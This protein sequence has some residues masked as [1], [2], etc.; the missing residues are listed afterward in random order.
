MPAE[1]RPDHSGPG[2]GETQGGPESGPS[3]E[4]GVLIR[5]LRVVVGAVTLICAIVPPSLIFDWSIGPVAQV[6][7]AIAAGGLLGFHLVNIFRTRVDLGHWELDDIWSLLRSEILAGCVSPIVIIVL[8]LTLPPTWWMLLLLGSS[9]GFSQLI[10]EPV[11]REIRLKVA[12]AHKKHGTEHFRAR[13]FLEDFGVKKSLDEM[14]E[15]EQGPGIW[16]YLIALGEDP[17]QEGM[18]RT[19]SL[20]VYV[21]I[22][23][24]GF[25]GAASADVYVH[26]AVHGKGNQPGHSKTDEKEA[27]GGS[28]DDAGSDSSDSSDSGDSG[29]GQDGSGGEGSSSGETVPTAGRCQFN[30]GIG[31]PG[32]AKRDLYALYYGGEGLDATAPPGT[33]I[34]GCPSEV[35][36]LPTPE[37]PFV[38][39]VGRGED[40]EIITAAVTSR[41]GRP[42]IFLAPAAQRVIE[43][44]GEGVVPLGGY[45]RVDVMGDG[46]EGDMVPITTPEGTIVLVRSRKVLMDMPEYASPYLELPVAVAAAWTAAMCG[47]GEWLWP[48]EP[49]QSEGV[50]VYRFSRNAN[51]QGP[52]VSIVYDPEEAMATVGDL[53]YRSPQ[54]QLNQLELEDFAASAGE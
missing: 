1:E 10:Y 38:Y 9:F 53:E 54:A 6:V 18:S 2:E 23:C 37:G 20:I 19:R 32:W 29:D 11:Q 50:T 47:E 45:P 40:G 8:V 13:K 15:D 27:T 26:E 39:A 33:D 35:F 42:A 16:K 25:A 3:R 22:A 36:V 31:V 49:R 34:G 7:L 24:A 12:D 41:H 44:I 51:G 48:L 43:L 28:G 17:W 52:Q 46:R 5:C 21:L 4:R 30:I 14:A